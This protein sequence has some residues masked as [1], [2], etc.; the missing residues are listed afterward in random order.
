MGKPGEPADSVTLPTYDRYMELPGIPGD[1]RRQIAQWNVLSRWERSELGRQLR[2]L[3][4]SYGE[5]LTLIPVPKGTLAGWCAGIELTD[6]QQEQ[7]FERTG[8]LKGIPGDTQWR[9]RLETEGIR[10]EAL[11]EVPGLMSNTLW[12]AGTVLYWG[13]GAKAKRQLDLTNSDPAAHRVFIDW[14]RTLLE[15]EPDF[16]LGIHLHEGNDEG[17]AR[18]YWSGAVGLTETYIKPARSGHRKN[19][20]PFGIL[21]IRVRKSTNHW[22]RVMAW[23]DGLR[24]ALPV[25]RHS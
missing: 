17:G 10:V 24:T 5:I 18:R 15:P 23:I 8:S 14:V 2:R 7:I 20:L 11:A 3:G 21:R 19:H 12:L 1:L 6:A 13:E 25:S 22:I 16:V 9:R 4:L